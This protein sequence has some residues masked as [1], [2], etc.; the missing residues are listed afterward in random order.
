ML[1]FCDCLRGKYHILCH[2]RYNWPFKMKIH[3]KHLVVL[4]TESR[5]QFLL[6]VAATFDS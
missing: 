1:A 2:T 4:L 5:I 3:F 6:L